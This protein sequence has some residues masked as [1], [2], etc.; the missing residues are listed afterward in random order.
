MKKI[1]IFDLD[2]TLSLLDHR[3]HLVE[4]GNNKWDQFFEACGDDGPNQPVI[5]LCNILH[6]N[7]NIY[8]FSGRSKVVERKTRIWLKFHKVNYHFL[9][10]RGV[11]DYR[12]DDVLK[13]ELME[14]YI[15]D[16]SKIAWIFDD[17]NKVVKMW[18]SEGLP[19]FQVAEGEF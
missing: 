13:K 6:K 4:N 14:Y 12:L 2:G 17:R 1:V 16:K 19:C 18:R 15:K 11:K 5:N 10:M 3:R 7:H 8:I 9:F